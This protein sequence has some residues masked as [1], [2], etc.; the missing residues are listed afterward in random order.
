M[1]YGISL[2]LDNSSN[3]TNEFKILCAF[4]KIDPNFKF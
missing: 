4:S 3:H 1:E 2:L